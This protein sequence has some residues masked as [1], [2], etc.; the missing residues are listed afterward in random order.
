MLLNFELRR[1]TSP[2]TQHSLTP[3]GPVSTGGQ[4]LLVPILS[5]SLSTVPS[6]T[7][8]TLTA[9]TALLG[10]DWIHADP[11]GEH[12]RLDV[13]SVVKLDS[14]K[15]LDINYKGIVA[16]TDET[17]AI[18]AGG[19]KEGSL[20]WGT[21]YAQWKFQ[22]EDEAL[23]GLQ[24]KLWVASGRFNVGGDGGVEVEYHVF[25]VGGQ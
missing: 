15:H 20:P 11:S 9:T 2:C 18:L 14:G 25:E 8:P 5:T 7:G 1:V 19:A 22:A 21:V 3:T 6:Y 10:A 24:D 23:K 4:T 16:V 17:K 13:R 12:L